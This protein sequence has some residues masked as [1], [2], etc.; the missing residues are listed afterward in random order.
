[1]NHSRWL[2]AC[3]LGTALALGACASPYRYEYEDSVHYYAP[4]A[5]ESGT[6]E[7]IDVT[8]NGGGGPTPRGAG[9]GGGGR[10]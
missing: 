2:T 8:P 3:A 10:R 1:M 4:A 9:G 7:R 5:Y 6:V